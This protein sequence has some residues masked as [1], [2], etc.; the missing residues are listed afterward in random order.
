MLPIA[1]KQL[2]FMLAVGVLSISVYIVIWI[3]ENALNM[4]KILLSDY[5][6][7]KKR[8]RYKGKVQSK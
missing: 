7:S 8:V 5:D 2:L 1:I 3:V 6:F 4:K